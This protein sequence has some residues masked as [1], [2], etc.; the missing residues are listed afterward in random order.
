MTFPLTRTYYESFFAAIHPLPLM[1]ET[2][3]DT[4]TALVDAVN[5]K[6]PG[7]RWQLFEFC[8]LRMYVI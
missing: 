4:V 7:G 8:D 1:L 3:K 5:V 2:I 6:V